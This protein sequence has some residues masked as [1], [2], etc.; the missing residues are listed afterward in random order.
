MPAVPDSVFDQLVESEIAA[1]R[2]AARQAA[3]PAPGQRRA[4]FASPVDWRDHWIYFLMVDRFNNP[5]HPPNSGQIGWNQRFSYHQGGT[6]KGIQ[7]CLP[8][9]KSLGVGA[10][11]ITPVVK[12]PAPN[13]AYNYHGYAAQ[14]LLAVDGRFGSDGSREK[15]ERELRELVDAAH[16]NGIYV[17]LDIVLNHMAR[18]FDYWI[19]GRLT[20][21]YSNWNVLR[22]APLAGLEP[23]IAWLNGYGYPVPD[24]SG[25]LPDPDSL[26]PD[27]AVHPA[28][29][30][31]KDFFRRRG[32]KLSDTPD[33]P[34]KDRG[35]AVGDFETMRQLVV[36]YQSEPE[37]AL[38]ERWGRNPVLTLLVR[39][40]S[41]LIARYDFDGFRIDTAK[42]VEPVMLQ[43]FGNAI[44][45]FALSLGKRNFFTFG[46][47]WDNDE[48]LAR[49]VGR[50]AGVTE[51]FGID[52]AKDFP[53][54]QLLRQLPKG[55]EEVQALP[56][57][58]EKRK[59]YEAELLT[60]HGEASRFFVTF[61]DNHDQSERIRHP[62]TSDAQVKQ[63]IG[64]LYTLQGIPCLYYGTEQDLSGTVHADGKPDLAQFE[65]VREALWGKP[66]AFDTNGSTFA[67]IR[68]L[69]DL[70]VR[71]P[72][73]RYGRQYFRVISGNGTDFG[74]A[75]GRQGVIA[76]SR[77]LGEEEVVVVA[78]T[79]N[80]TSFNGHVLI[81]RVINYGVAHFKVFLTNLDNPG[82]LSPVTKTASAI[83]WEGAERRGSAAA[84]SIAVSLQP[85][86]IQV[87]AADRP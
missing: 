20:D 82:T 60:S 56:E 79:S 85:M 65:G 70:R 15:A 61:L 16:D 73:L 13:W 2:L 57:L 4:P 81:D 51:G 8:Y 9:L 41:Y 36:E 25:P 87:L 67:W 50:N 21:K 74:P 46:E 23:E 3:N 77:I 44:R 34:S 66:N 33:W 48:N 1:A 19:D 53:L 39:A 43:Y 18:V 37:D 42:Y 32:S 40:Y 10:I 84:A 14:D 83:F 12:N 55:M 24:W 30:F 68:N 71:F 75:R 76:F 63:A 28:R 35:F 5:T 38:Y 59:S 6:F 29:D 49:F 54:F 17:I 80:T 58:F 62:E 52:A 72:A 27:D 64:L 78:N 31:R 11:W 69:S 7:D 45:E 47:V 22:S 86:E 26:H